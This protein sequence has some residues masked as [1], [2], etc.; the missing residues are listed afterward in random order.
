VV[1]RKRE[2]PFYQIVWQIEARIL[3]HL[4]KDLPPAV[5]VAD[6]DHATKDPSIRLEAED[7]PAEDFIE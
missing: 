7:R 2:V 3:Q 6:A 1:E 4:F 5:V